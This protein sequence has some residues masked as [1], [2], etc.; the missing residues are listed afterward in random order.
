LLYREGISFYYKKELQPAYD[1]FNFCIKNNYRLKESYLYRGSLFL[2]TNQKEKACQDFFE[3]KR[4]GNTEAD[5]YIEQ[6]CR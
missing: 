4:L 5:K 2:E 1:N 6:Y 3:S